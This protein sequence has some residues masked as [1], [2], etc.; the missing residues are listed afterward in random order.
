MSYF[1]TVKNYLLELEADI[2]FEEEDTGLFI[3]TIAGR[4]IENMILDCEGD[5]L[6]LEQMVIPVQKE[7]TADYRRLLQMNRALVHGAF[8]LNDSQD[9]PIIAF[10]DTLQLPHLDINELEGTLNALTFALVENL[11]ELIAMSAA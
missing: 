9:L 2:T 3:I 7:R 4:G 5:I 1:Q 10:R 11:D 8:V 6:V